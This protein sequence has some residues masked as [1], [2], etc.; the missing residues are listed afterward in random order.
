MFDVI[1]FLLLVIALW[2]AEV[3]LAKA[4]FIDK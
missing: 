3:G 2:F 4:F 1:I